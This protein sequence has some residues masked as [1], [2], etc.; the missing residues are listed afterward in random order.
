LSLDQIQ[1]VVF[2][3]AG[4][5]KAVDA[6]SYPT[7]VDFFSGLPK[8]V[9]SNRLFTNLVEFLKQEDSGRILDIELVLWALHQ[10]RDSAAAF[11]GE[12]RPLS[13]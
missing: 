1:V 11:K 6:D 12:P 10:L 5:S 8:S 2:A 3:G 7:T 13:F 4:A 9:T